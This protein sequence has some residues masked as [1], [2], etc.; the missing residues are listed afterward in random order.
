MAGTGSSVAI[1]LG[2]DQLTPDVD[3]LFRPFISFDTT[4]ERH[5]DEVEIRGHKVRVA[6]KQA[7]L[8]MKM[9]RYARKD[10]ADITALIRALAVHSPCTHLSKLWI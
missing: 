6:S 2:R 3:G 10:Y 8:A 5:F 4:D 7:L 9:A 1:H